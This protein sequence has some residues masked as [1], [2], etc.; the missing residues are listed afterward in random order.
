MEKSLSA[1]HTKILTLPERLRDVPVIRCKGIVVVL[2]RMDHPSFGVL[3]V[4]HGASPNGHG[5]APQILPVAG[6]SAARS[7]GGREDCRFG[8]SFILVFNCFH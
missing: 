8:K 1:S 4:L 2:K 5:V 3:V 6:P 7:S